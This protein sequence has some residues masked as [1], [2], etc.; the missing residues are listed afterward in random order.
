MAEINI[1]QRFFEAELEHNGVKRRGAS[2]WL[3]S[4]SDAGH[5]K[6]TAAVAFN[7]L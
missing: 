7:R 1:Y 6:Y 3:V 5:I 2:V 4:N